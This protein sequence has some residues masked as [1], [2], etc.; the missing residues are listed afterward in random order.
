MDG[1]NK[2]LGPGDSVLRLYLGLWPWPLDRWGC[3]MVQL[4]DIGWGASLQEEAVEY[5]LRYLW[6]TREFYSREAVMGYMKLRVHLWIK[7]NLDFRV[8]ILQLSSCHT[9]LLG[10]ENTE[11]LMCLNK[12]KRKRKWGE[13][14][15]QTLIA[16]NII[17]KMWRWFFST[18]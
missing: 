7:K 16:E 2:C 1:F 11:P 8:Q 10:I 6:A 13:I 3:Y 15:E 14:K 5:T 9:F 18:K 17:Q 12:R 4:W